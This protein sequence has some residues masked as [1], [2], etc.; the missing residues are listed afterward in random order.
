MMQ[1]AMPP[2]DQVYLE[3][4]SMPMMGQFPPAA[5]PQQFQPM[6]QTG[7]PSDQAMLQR[8]YDEV[9]RTAVHNQIA[10]VDQFLSA[11]SVGQFG[12][13]TVSR[14]AP[15]TMPQNPMQYS[16]SSG[17]FMQAGMQPPRVDTI[18][19][20]PSR[21]D[22]LQPASMA[23]GHV[24]GVQMGHGPV[25]ASWQGVQQDWVP[26]QRGAEMPTGFPADANRFPRSF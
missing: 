26:N 13:P 8:R 15:M 12:G 21:M 6:G 25:D 17:Q 7:F 9:S 1:G 5:P 3:G 10:A 18:M 20:P 23:M 22:T 4:Q 14:P 24:E 11:S 16:N 2:R 19:P